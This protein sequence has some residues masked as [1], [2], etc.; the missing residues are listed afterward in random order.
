MTEPSQLTRIEPREELATNNA[1][2][3]MKIIERAATSADFDVAKLEKLLDVKDRWEANEARKAYILALTAFKKEPPTII[4]NRSASFGGA[5]KTAY[6]YANLA[7]CVG[8]IAPALS[9]HGL[10]HGWSME[11]TE[12]GI[13]VTCTLTHEAG[14]SESI[15]MRAPADTSG[16]KNSIQAIGS[17]ISYLS[18]YSLLAITGLAAEDQDDDGGRV[19]GIT[20]EQK[21]RLV[22][23]M[24]E[25]PNLDTAAFLKYMNVAYLDMLPANRFN[26]ALA[27]LERKRGAKS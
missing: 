27:A 8:V 26:D 12:A 4:K 1:A 19:D 23:I 15:V 13:A 22:A 5:G 21:D 17:T 11:Q 14:H 3:L 16:S 10:S 7:Q 6:D 25:I 24:R 20:A 2:M 9:Q 18:R